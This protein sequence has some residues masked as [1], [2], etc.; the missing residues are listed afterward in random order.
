M[1]AARSWITS[2]RTRLALGYF[3]VIVLLAG[4]WGWTLFGP[5]E[6]NVRTQQRDELAGMAR[7]ASVAVTES[8]APFSEIAGKVVE[9]ST[10]RMTVVASD[11]VVLADTAADP[12]T[13]ENHA[14]RPEIAAALAG[15]TGFAQ[16]VSG[17]TNVPQVYVAVPGTRG[18]QALAVRL[19]APQRTIADL[20]AQARATSLF[21]LVVA[22][23]VALWVGWRLSAVAIEPVRGLTAA[24]RRMAGGDLASSVPAAEGELSELSGALTELRDQM[25][26][27]VSG[28]ESERR[29]LR[30]VLDGL[31]DAV[32]LLEGDRVA[33]ANDAASRVLRTPFGGW[34]GRRLDEDTLP[35]SLSSTVADLSDEPDT[36]TRSR[37]IGPDPTGRWLRV[38][39]LPA[40]AEVAGAPTVE[41]SLVIIT[42]IT[43]RMRLDAVRTDF[44]ANASHELKTPTAAI[45]LLAEGARAAA[46]DGDTEQAMT[47]LGQ[48]DS[49][50]KKLIRLVADH[51]DLSRLERSPE[52]GSVT[53]VRGAV[54][55]SVS[56]HQAAA[57]AKSLALA[58]DLSQVRGEDV[59]ALAD[60]T[61]VAVALDNL[62]DNAVLYTESGGVEV[63]VNADPEHISVSVH[64]TGIGIPAEALPR[65][66]E[67]FYRVDPAR[68]R[69]TGGTG[70]GLALVRHFAERSGGSVEIVSEPG[71][72]TT[73]TL[74]LPRA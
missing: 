9:G 27:R 53:D 34:V 44:V 6:S 28:L 31:T 19:S 47:F 2:Y 14:G 30:T 70:L 46:S 72:G 1:S 20:V 36:A 50:A 29:N 48:I 62:L 67:R 22:L 68:A 74:R 61:D 49:E 18:G 32:F 41:R 4:A 73:V 51:L 52:P 42:D 33:L 35:A 54:D 65:V 66:F 57:R 21:A 71:A 10:L 60:P 25:R 17:T 12:K 15:R 64:D 69:G 26:D 55:L 56:S 16:R 3:V 59:Y 11:G 7:S 45:S 63:S 5:L 38:A 23:I 24:A 39:V 40:P 8:K 43:E 13:M 58:T 37:T